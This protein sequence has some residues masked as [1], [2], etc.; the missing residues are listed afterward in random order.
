MTTIECKRVIR[1]G[2]TPWLSH[3]KRMTHSA[4]AFPGHGGPRCT[5][6]IQGIWAWYKRRGTSS[7][8]KRKVFSMGF[9]EKIPEE[10]MGHTIEG[11]E[12][13]SSSEGRTH[14]EWVGT[15][16]RSDF[17][18]GSNCEQPPTYVW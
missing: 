16:R 9:F 13:G 17:D 14:T 15:T 3:N 8:K 1:T 18:V 10:C 4:W 5:A 2:M 7:F 11:T 6:T 12:T